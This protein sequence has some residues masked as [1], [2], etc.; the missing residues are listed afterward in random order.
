MALST[1]VKNALLALA[2]PSKAKILQRFFKTGKGEY[3]EGDIFLGIIVPLQRAVAKDYVQLASLDDITILLNDAYHECRLTA[4]F[5]LVLQYEKSKSF[6]EKENIVSFYLD[7]LDGINNWDLVDSSAYKILGRFCYEQNDSERMDDLLATGDL[8]KIRIAIVATL[9]WTKKGSTELI[10]KYVLETI[11]HP[12]D[13]IHKANGWM[14]REMGKVDE[15]ALIE[16]L[17]VYATHLPR[18]T[19]RYAL[20]RLAPTVKNYYMKL[21]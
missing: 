10:R 13:L 9:Y 15:H 20:E 21:T 1:D 3:A 4:V 6:R 5:I 16:F 7:H 8:W 14:L 12:H 17:D 11:A 19:L 2:D 18:T